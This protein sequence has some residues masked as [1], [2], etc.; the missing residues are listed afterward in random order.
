MRRVLSPSLV[1]RFLIFALLTTVLTSLAFAKNNRTFF[2]PQ[3]RVTQSIDESQLVTLKGNT[4]Y[5]ADAKHDRGP[6]DGNERTGHIILLLRRAPEQE[7]VLDALMDNQQ[8]SKSVNYH[9]WLTAEE[10]GKNF[11]PADSDMDK[12]TGW[13]KSKGFNV[14][15]VP[16]GRTMIIFS[17]TVGQVQNAFHT[18]IHYLNVKG[19]IHRSNMSDPQVPAAIA[20]V[21]AG[22]HRLNDFHPAP[23][24]VHSGIANYNPDSKRMERVEG[25]NPGPAPAITYSG[26]GSTDWDV[27]PQDWY[28]IY[29]ANPTFTAG[30]TGAGVTIAVIEETGITNNT[31]AGYGS[32]DIQSFR[33]AFGLPA[34]PTSGGASSTQGGINYYNG[35]VPGATACTAAATPTSTDA[36]GEALLDTEW[37]GAG[38]PNALIDFVACS[39]P[40]SS[41]GSYGTDISAET[42][43]NYL[44]STVT[45]TS[46]SYGE[47]EVAAGSSGTAFYTAVWQQG[48]A[49]GI[50]HVVSTGD[51]GP[52]QCDQSEYVGYYATADNALSINAMSSSIYNIAAGGTDFSDVYQADGGTPSTYWSSTNSSTFESALSYIP[53]VSWGA[54]CANPLWA[55][56]LQKQGNTKFGTTYTPISICNNS[57]VVTGSGCLFCAVGTGGGPSAY[58]SIPTWQSVYAGSGNQGN[59][60]TTK[61]NTPDVSMFASSGW[62][63]HALLYCQSDT[64]GSCTYSV[65]N[66]FAG[67]MVAGG[68]SFVGPS[69]NGVMALIN[70]K[71]GRQG[72]ANYTLYNLAA[73]E[74]GTTGSPSSTIANCSGSNLGASVGSSCIFRDIANDTPCLSGTTMCGTGTSGTSGSGALT[75]TEIGSDTAQFCSRSTTNPC[76]RSGS[77]SYGIIS[78]GGTHPT[79]FNDAYRTAQGYDLATGLGSID[80]TNLVNGWNTVSTGFTSTTTISANPT[81]ITNGSGATTLTGTVTATQRLGVPAGNVTFYIGSNSGTN[82]GTAPLVESCSGLANPPAASAT[83]VGVATL[84]VIGSQLNGGSNSIIAYFPGDGANDAASTSSAV[85]VTYNGQQPQ[86]ITCTTGPPSS[87]AYNSSFTLVCT[88]S[89]GLAVAYTGAGSCSNSGATYTMTSATG[90]CAVNVNQPGDGS[91]PAAPQVQYTVNATLATNSVT[92]TTTAPSSAAYGSHFTVAASGLGTGATTY[93]S[94]GSCS[95]SGATYTMTSGSGTCTVTA[96][97]A[98]DSSYASANSSE[99][100]SATLASNACSFATQGPSSAEYGS[101]FTVAASGLG[102]GAITYISGGACTNS[103]ATYTMTSGTGTCSVTATQASDDNYQSCEASES[104]TAEPAHASLSLTTAGPSTYGQP[105]TFT[106]TV[107]SDTGAVKGRTTKR[108]KDVNGQVNWSANTGCST[109]TVSG[110][111]PQTATCTSSILPG[112][113]G[114]TDTVTASYAASDNNHT[115]AS[116]SV[117]QTVNPAPNTVTFTTPAPSSAEYGSSFTVAASGLGTGA[118]TYTSDGVVCTN[119]GATYTMIAGSGACTVTATQAAD[120]DYQTAS[121]SESVTAEPAQGEVSVALTSGTNPST[122]GGS[123]TYTATV[124]SDTGA[125]KGRG[126]TKRPRNLNGSVS[127]SANTGCNASSVSGNPPQTATCAT[128]ILPGSGGGADTVTATYTTGDSNHTTASGSV[129]QTVNPANQTISCTGVPAGAAYNSSFMVSCAC[130]SG[131]PASYASAGSCTNSGATYSMTSGSGSCS[132]IANCLGNSNYNPAPPVT[133]TVNAALAGQ[134]ITVTTPAPGTAIDN[135]TFTVVASTNS[136]L[137]ITFGAAP[138]TVCSISGTTATSATYMIAKTAAVNKVCTITLSQPGNSDYSAAGTVTETTKIATLQTPTVSFTTTATIAQYGTTISVTASSNETGAV[139]ST[140][141]IASTTPAICSVGVPTSSGTTVTAPVTVLT[142]SGTCFLNA[143]WAVNTA[144]KAASKSLAI[145]AVKAKP[146]VSLTGAPSSANKGATFT[147]TATSNELSG[148]ASTPSITAAGACTVGSATSTGPAA[149]QAT[150]TITKSAGTCK[151]KAA[152]A[153]T[154]DY[155]AASATPQTTSAK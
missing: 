8:D 91:W 96:T 65:P 120:S 68:T 153:A 128:L 1:C 60:S 50:T 38:A 53:E 85:V 39:S 37:A 114:G 132:V 101:S 3:A 14:D 81:T 110:N 18:Q 75:S 9:N 42:I 121:A 122:Y 16:P 79:T 6:V 127:W 43:V 86:T 13:L 138:S 137:P 113:G 142:G 82:L 143:T 69:L 57:N 49:E 145:T 152:W 32:T 30:I 20:P 36:E 73:Q 151:T 149:Y 111:P 118:I 61:R 77:Q 71:Y 25:S 88:A 108:P 115:T 80:V 146:T 119:S 93:T 54:Y 64:G 52:C 148:S 109:S 117:S 29:N 51:G 76:W 58:N 94:G 131:L 47:C 5:L 84:S 27:T 59:V 34:Y 124:T 21:I 10:F 136:G 66:D 107:T 2:V 89:S 90:T 130:S 74:Y 129:S 17:G 100:V 83:C 23:L 48:S 62:W 98:A 40:G 22:F 134:N 41:I 24:V 44:Y 33:S 147:V 95:N 116:G 123:V 19:E 15:E 112:G 104:V 87:A 55:S 99:S 72:N 105:V 35:T 144:Y 92:F 154:T 78:T 97:Q 135:S 140:P 46:L 26:S 56:L 28:T 4:I 45:S 7:A 150:V 102:T 106:A 31:T 67:Y 70:Q 63:S 155:D 141:V 125:V 11:G 133:D 103:G 12:V 126:K 139:T